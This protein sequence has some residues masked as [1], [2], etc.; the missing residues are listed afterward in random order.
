MGPYLFLRGGPF[1]WSRRGPAS[2]SHADW[3]SPVLFLGP[4]PVLVDPGVYGYRTSSRDADRSWSGHSAVSFATPADPQPG[5]T[6]RWQ[7]IPRPARLTWETGEQGLEVRG[8]VV[9][10]RPR[11]PLLW[12]RILRYNELESIWLIQDRITG[13]IDGPVTWAF[14]FAPGC[15]VNPESDGVHVELASGRRLVLDVEPLG[16]IRVDNGWVASG[17]GSREPAPVLRRRL[18]SMPETTRVRITPAD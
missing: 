1:G 5:G 11:G 2:H 8:E 16:E 6:F 10:D 13:D 18:D 14:H 17:Y 12:Q 7:S 3:L 4:D 9:W 15:R